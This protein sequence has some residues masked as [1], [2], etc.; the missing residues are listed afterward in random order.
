MNGQGMPPCLEW[1]YIGLLTLLRLR[2][3]SAPSYEVHPLLT[4][5][6]PSEASE[7]LSTTFLLALKGPDINGLYL[8]NCSRA[9]SLPLQSVLSRRS[10]IMTSSEGSETWSSL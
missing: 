5:C 7:T 10:P 9:Y 6:L 8:I 1:P 2:V 3:K 4:H